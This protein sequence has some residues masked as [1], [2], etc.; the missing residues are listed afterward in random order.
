MAGSRLFRPNSGL[1]VREPTSNTQANKNIINPPRFAQ[2]GGLSS[3]SP[4][5]LQ[6]NGMT[7]QAPG[8]TLRKVP[9]RNREG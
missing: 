5:G 4:R 7:V 3:G 1:D 2:F 9:Q 6:K 8:S